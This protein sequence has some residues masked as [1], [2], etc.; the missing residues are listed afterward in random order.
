MVR[1][2]ATMRAALRLIGIAGHHEDRDGVPGLH[3]LEAQGPVFVGVEAEVADLSCQ[4]LVVRGSPR[5]SSGAERSS[6]LGGRD[7]CGSAGELASP[8]GADAYAPWQLRGT[9]TWAI[10]LAART[11]EVEV[12]TFCRRYSPLGYPASA[13]LNGEL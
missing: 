13:M 9:L 3:P 11:T 10:R 12:E 7:M 6:N 2:A 8:H 1:P 4:R 5:A